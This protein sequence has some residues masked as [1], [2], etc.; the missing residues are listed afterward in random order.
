ML[1]DITN[2][3][4]EMKI[5]FRSANAYAKNGEAIIQVGIEIKDT[6]DLATLTKKFRQLPGVTSVSRTKQ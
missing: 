2:V 3:L 5:P 1:L 4:V 6:A